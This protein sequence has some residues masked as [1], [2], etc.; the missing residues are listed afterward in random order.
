M[1]ENE[2]EDD[3]LDDSFE[4]FPDDALDELEHDAVQSTQAGKAPIARDVNRPLWKS[5]LI[6]SFGAQQEREPGKVSPKE[7]R[8]NVEKSLMSSDYED[9][10]DDDLEGEVLGGA[11]PASHAVQ[12]AQ[13]VS[14]AGRAGESTQ[15]EQWRVNR[16]A[17]NNSDTGG[18]GKQPTAK[19]GEVQR[20]FITRQEALDDKSHSELQGR[21]ATTDSQS[22]QSKGSLEDMETLQARVRE[23]LQEQKALQASLEAANSAAFSRSGEVAII[24]ANQAKAAKEHERNM[25]AIQ[26]LHAEEASKQRIALEQANE[27]RK[28]ASD[29]VMFLEH[30]LREQTEKLQ[31]LQR[32]NKA[33]KSTSLRDVSIGEK[34]DTSPIT[35]PKKKKNL[36]YRDG[37]DD[38]EIAFAS[39]KKLNGGRSGGGTPKP[40]TKRKRKGIDDSPAKPLQLSQANSEKS[41]N[42]G[43]VDHG[44]ALGESLKQS[45]AREDSRFEFLQSILS[46][47]IRPGDKRFIE[48]MTNFSFPSA[49]DA[50]FS[51][52]IL[53]ETSKV[54]TNRSEENFPVS[55][56]GI[57]L[58][59][60]SK[61]LREKYYS[62]LYLLIDI[63]TFVLSLD[64]MSTALKIMDD[65][66]E[67]A[68][69][70]ADIN[71]IPRCYKGP[72]SQLQADVDVASCLHL[73]HLT[74]LE[75]IYND[76][77]IKRF[78][79]LMRVDFVL[80]TMQ[81]NQPLDHILITVDLLSISIMKDSFGTISAVDTSDQRQNEAFT[82]A[83]LS[84]LLELTPRVGKSERR[85]DH[86]E[87]ANMR[88][89]VLGL[90]KGICSTPNGGEA[91]ATHHDVIGKLVRLIY[92]ELDALYDFRYD[93]HLSAE[94][95]NCA[96][97][98]VYY[99]LNNHASL[100]NLQSKLAK[101]PGGSHKYLV[102]LTRLAFSEGLVLEAGI[103]DEIVESARELLEE[104]VTPEE[105]EALWAAFAVP[106]AQKQAGDVEMG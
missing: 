90:L 74:A 60:W 99:L 43:A 52:I 4:N 61:S 13:P 96:L 36:P 24:R 97:R 50:M 68:Q 17:G 8:P 94:Q 49:A 69:R 12:K 39:P 21:D 63:L 70:T 38:E 71:A 86:I 18:W 73:L 55:F 58:S 16:F 37:F 67:V 95:V 76:A 51:S 1:A 75:C 20:N 81:Q 62:P 102:S 91:M 34:S 57:I 54:H 56:C 83:R 65:L 89:A 5:Q 32:S 6:P 84:E 29:N 88:L 11:R 78:W 35:T 23:L 44:P 42:R 31:S 48:A 87:I 28:K 3:L 105:G 100:I 59:L 30:D 64:S 10:D 53:D 101:I 93:H 19:Q 77:D 47:R 45:L 7:S 80:L 82:L 26:K 15:R 104:W 40:G 27:E 14:G 33:A 66:V 92:G 22:M 46:H 72:D 106:P 25:V 2:D 85:Y 79:K 41:I 103:E 98:I 9:Y